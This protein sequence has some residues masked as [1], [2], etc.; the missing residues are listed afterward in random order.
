MKS[1]AVVIP[2]TDRTHVYRQG[3]KI[4]FSVVGQHTTDAARDATD[5]LRQLVDD[6]RGP[7]EFVADLREITGF[8]IDGRVF[9]QDAFRETRGR[10]RMITVVKGTALARMTAS[11]VG[12]YAGIKVRSLDTIEEA[13]DPRLDPPLES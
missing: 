10:I 6:I 9:W 5:Q 2:L 11:A 12:L 1:T 7:V 3:R 4:I 13:L 8:T